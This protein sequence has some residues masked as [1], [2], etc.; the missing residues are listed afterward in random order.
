MAS[1]TVVKALFCIA[2][3]DK[4]AGRRWVGWSALDGGSVEALEH[5][6]DFVLRGTRAFDEVDYL[7]QE[8]YP[9]LIR[10]GGRIG[11]FALADISARNL[12]TQNGSTGFHLPSGC[13]ET[14]KVFPSGSLNQATLA[15]VGE[16]QIP[17]SPCS[18]N[19]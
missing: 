2:Y 7:P 5:A 1:G 6:A 4:P 17:E 9:L 10:V 16:V 14:L 19:P 13:S 15:P 18:K 8:D 3:K 12:A 11:D